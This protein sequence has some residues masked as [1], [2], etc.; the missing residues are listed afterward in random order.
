MTESKELQEECSGCGYGPVECVRVPPRPQ[1]GNLE[2]WLCD[3]CAG[4]QVGN[5]VSYPSNSDYRE[6]HAVLRSMAAIANILVEKLRRE[7]V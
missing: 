2:H 3:F 1:T 7:A 5:A 4:S 6:H